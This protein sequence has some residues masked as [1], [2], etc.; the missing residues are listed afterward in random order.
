MNRY[1]HEHTNNYRTKKSINNDQH[2]IKDINENQ[3]TIN[4]NMNVNNNLIEYAEFRKKKS[5][6][7]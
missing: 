2:E 3:R 1:N 4:L 6:V 7:Q 5:Y